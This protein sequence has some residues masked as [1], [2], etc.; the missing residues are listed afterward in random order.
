MK[1]RE[2]LNDDN[3]LQCIEKRLA[4]I[5]LMT[6]ILAFALIFLGSTAIFSNVYIA[7][8][9]DNPTNNYIKTASFISIFSITIIGAFNLTTK[10]TQ[11]R[12]GWK[13]LNK[14]V[15]NYKAGVIDAKKLIN[16]Y[17]ESEKILGCIE[18]NYTRKTEKTS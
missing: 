16:S 3:F 7:V 9:A 4:K 12:N 8:Y 11:S 17:E 14:S 1:K 2:E 5:K 15:I 10:V 13:L 18:F 6:N